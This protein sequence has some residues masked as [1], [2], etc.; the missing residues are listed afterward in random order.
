MILF[1]ELLSEVI[2]SSD[3]SRYSLA[4]LCNIDPSYMT[5]LCNG[6]RIKLSD[7]KL[8]LLIEN[9]LLTPKQ[10][11]DFRTAYEIS[12]IGEEKYKQYIAIKNLIENVKF[13][14]GYTAE[15]D[16]SHTFGKKKHFQSQHDVYVVLKAIIETE[17]SKNNSHINL[18]TEAN[19][20]FVIELLHSIFAVNKDILV[21]H[22]IPLQNIQ[23]N[24]SLE[25]NIQSINAI[26]P[27]LISDGKYFP[28]YYYD[29]Y[30]DY[31]NKISNDF[32]FPFVVITSNYVLCISRKW[33][34]AI[35]HTEQE[36]IDTY[37]FS[38]ENQKEKSNLF[39][40][41]MKSALDKLQYF[42]EDD[43]HNHY[44]SSLID[45]PCIAPFLEKRVIQNAA[46]PN[47][48][49]KEE[50]INFFVKYIEHISQL[51]WTS[52]FSQKGLKDFLNTGII[53]EIPE[54]WMS[55]L[56][57]LDRAILIEKLLN[58]MS[59]GLCN[60]RI[61]KS[62]RLNIPKGVGLYSFTNQQ[63][64]FVFPDS[65]NSN[66]FYDLQEKSTSRLISQFFAFLESSSWVYSFDET[67]E[68]I[69][70]ILKDFKIKYNLT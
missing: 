35:L 58:A 64:S 14:T 2:Q 27:L 7:E 47:L 33:D 49:N 65:K 54:K 28:Y 50:T 34:S 5:K 55:A 43:K 12:K 56:P 36:I 53:T 41:E 19:H 9:L 11:E 57:I 21:S 26:V 52:Y 30:A 4:R 60:A 44:S 46:A 10:E 51:N 6:T 59:Q 48:P 40:R 22:I 17:S 62:E 32:V 37:H 45:Q 8:D 25:F 39:G 67:I 42:M 29:N 15:A 61:V 1:S 13:H 38:F 66:L 63:A 24:N 69:K 31:S 18:L 20:T 70:R 16:Y 3:L 23:N 68:I